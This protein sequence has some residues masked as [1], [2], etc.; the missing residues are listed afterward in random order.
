MPQRYIPRGRPLQ[1]PERRWLACHV[2]TDGEA[3]VAARLG[4]SRHALARALGALPVYA[5]TAATIE[6][7]RAQEVT[8]G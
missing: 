6:A 2:R 4:L 3:A 5:S 8:H 7:A 1:E